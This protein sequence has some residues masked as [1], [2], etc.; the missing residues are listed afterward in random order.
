MLVSNTVTAQ[1]YKVAPKTSKKEIQKENS[2]ISVKKETKKR[3]EQQLIKIDKELNL[4]K[5]QEEQTKELLQLYF[6]ET[7]KIQRNKDL[8]EE[9]RRVQYQENRDNFTEKFEAILSSEQLV[10]YHKKKNEAVKSR[11]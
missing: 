1:K 6:V 4:N 3:V 2:S 8:T 5:E 7:E 10:I 9:K 11:K